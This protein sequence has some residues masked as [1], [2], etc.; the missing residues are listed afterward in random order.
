MLT[1]LIMGD[2]VFEA[3][4]RVLLSKVKHQKHGQEVNLSAA[5]C[6]VLHAQL[7][8]NLRR[9]VCKLAKHKW[10]V[11]HEKPATCERCGRCA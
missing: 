5:M 10:L 7:P 1:D 11:M 8:M 9:T 6:L 2:V 3:V 4:R